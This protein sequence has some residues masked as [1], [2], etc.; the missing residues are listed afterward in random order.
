MAAV[1]RDEAILD[2]A[3][4][5]GSGRRRNFNVV[6][7]LQCCVDVVIKAD[8]MFPWVESYEVG[9]Q[10]YHVPEPGPDPWKHSSDRPLKASQCRHHFPLVS[11]VAK[12]IKVNVHMVYHTVDEARTVHGYCQYSVWSG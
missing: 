3:R 1:C 2:D 8:V 10:S 11:L 6:I 12:L 5:S 9:Q 7:F 4:E